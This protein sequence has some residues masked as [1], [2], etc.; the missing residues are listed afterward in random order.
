MSVYTDDRLLNCND[1]CNYDSE[2]P[3]TFDC[4]TE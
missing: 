3:K 1:L 2:N 4:Y